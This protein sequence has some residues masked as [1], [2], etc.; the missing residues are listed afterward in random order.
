MNKFSGEL[1]LLRRP[2][3]LIININH[4]PR[5]CTRPT[6]SESMEQQHFKVCPASPVFHLVL[7]SHFTISYFLLSSINTTIPIILRH[8]TPPLQAHSVC[9]TKNALTPESVQLPRARAR[10]LLLLLL[11][12]AM[13]HPPP[14][15]PTPCTCT[16]WDLP[17][18][19]HIYIYTYISV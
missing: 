11:L 9:I 18:D 8:T 15:P 1:L 10:P 6:P 19:P 16:D 12:S 5:L 14:V 17:T 4:M 2:S 7:I 3:V 13:P